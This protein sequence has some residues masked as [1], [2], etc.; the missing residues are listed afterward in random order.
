VSSRTFNYA[1]CTAALSLTATQPV[2]AKPSEMQVSVRSA[3]IRMAALFADFKKPNSPG[4]SY[5]VRQNGKAVAQAS[6]GSADIAAGRKLSPNM[7][8]NIGSVSKSFTAAAVLTL[9]RAGK[10]KTTDTVKQHFPDLPDWAVRVTIADLIH[11]RSG[12]PD[13]LERPSDGARVDNTEGGTQLFDS[14]KTLFD[15]VSLDEIYASVKM[16]KV[17]VFEPGAK[18]NYSNVNYILLAML[19]EKT[20]GVGIEAYL[21]SNVLPSELKGRAK[22]ARF[23]ANIYTMPGAPMGYYKA[24]SGKDWLPRQETWDVRG[25]SNIFI[26]V[27]DLARW[28]DSFSLRPTTKGSFQDVQTTPGIFTGEG[29]E[30]AG[31]AYGLFVTKIGGEDVIYHPGG[32]EQ[33]TSGLYTIPSKRLSFAYSCNIRAQELVG[34]LQSGSGA[35]AMKSYGYDVVFRTWIGK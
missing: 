25:P 28:G 32:T 33:F 6:F 12:I 5:A 29:E 23:G 9:I 26:R 16:T 1:F 24:D 17:L 18:F 27:G 2:I 8:M 19:V 14:K 4:C 15:T 31:Y 10:I 13:F 30:K 35:E 21:K 20:S 22:E 34:A 3:K 7:P 11:M